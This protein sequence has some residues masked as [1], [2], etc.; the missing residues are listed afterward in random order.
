MHGV[1]RIVQYAA[2]RGREQQPTTDRRGLPMRSV[3]IVAVVG[4]G[5]LTCTMLGADPSPAILR[6]GGEGKQFRRPAGELPE[7]KE[8]PNPFTFAD[9]S[10]V[11]TAK[12]WERRRV[13]IKN[14]FED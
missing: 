9:G 2:R 11:R 6:A 13:E 12:D 1:A 5:A 14:L 4:V 3:Q 8:L 10:P 7:I